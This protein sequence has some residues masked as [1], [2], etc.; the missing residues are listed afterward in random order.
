MSDEAPIYVTV[1]DAARL[2]SLC[3]ASIYNFCNSGKIAYTKLG[4]RRLII[5]ESLLKLSQQ[6][7]A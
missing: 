1:K 4:R 7:A 2:T 5:R 6:E 3:E